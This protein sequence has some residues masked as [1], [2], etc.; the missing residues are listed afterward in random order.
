MRAR[1][2]IAAAIGLAAI[3]SANAEIRGITVV[4]AND[5]DKAVI[6][7]LASSSPVVSEY[8]QTIVLTDTQPEQDKQGV[9]YLRHNSDTEEA[10][11]Q[12]GMAIITSRDYIAFSAHR[13]TAREDFK[14]TEASM[15]RALSWIYG[16]G[17]PLEVQRV[18]ERDFEREVRQTSP[19]IENEFKRLRETA[20]EVVYSDS[21]LVW[22]STQDTLPINGFL[23]PLSAIDWRTDFATYFAWGHLR[24]EELWNLA[25][26]TSFRRKA[27]YLSDTLGIIRKP[28]R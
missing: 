4:N 16:F 9:L 21:T 10:F 22:K 24:E 1:K 28:L 20:P 18:F 17:L 12:A 25:S 27:E 6:E 15:I 23:T 26:D 11:F 5:N 7:Q 13:T 19:T 8:I 3:V 14:D 2:S